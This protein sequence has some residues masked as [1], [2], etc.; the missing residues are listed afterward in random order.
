M[1]VEELI[2]YLTE[3]CDPDSEVYAD[4]SGCIYELIDLR[5]YNGKVF[6]DAI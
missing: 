4:Y 3:N 2:Q 1:T 5:T 6:L